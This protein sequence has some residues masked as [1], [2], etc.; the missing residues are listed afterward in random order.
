MQDANQNIDQIFKEYY[1]NHSLEPQSK[2]WQNIDSKLK[3]KQIAK[4]S[5]WIK[6]TI[7]ISSAVILAVLAVFQFKTEEPKPI[8]ENKKEILVEKKDSV[9]VT[10]VQKTEI[11]TPKTIVKTEKVKAPKVETA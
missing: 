8:I 10:P 6:W 1:Q 2:L 7:G 5:K 4:S 3:N 9:I 11:E